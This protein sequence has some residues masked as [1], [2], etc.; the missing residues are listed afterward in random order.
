MPDRWCHQCFICRSDELELWFVALRHYPI[1][2]RCPPAGVVFVVDQHLVIAHS[3][4]EGPQRPPIGER[5]L[6][7]LRRSRRDEGGLGFKHRL[8][9][10]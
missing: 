6:G 1:P 7:G 10:G 5:V 3:Q 2:Q 9:L 4:G 8:D